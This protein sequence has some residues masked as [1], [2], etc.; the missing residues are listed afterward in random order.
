MPDDVM[1][2]DEDQDE[3]T[4]VVHDD[5]MKRLLDYQRQLRERGEAHIPAL[6]TTSLADLTTVEAQAATA[7]ATTDDVLDLTQV[8]E[9]QA[10]VEIV[11]LPEIEETKLEI[12]EEPGEDSIEEP[13]GEAETSSSTADP[14]LAARVERLESSIERIG[15]M[16][17]S[18]RSDF[19]DLTIRAD[20]RIAEIE[21]VLAEALGPR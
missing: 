21:E 3:L 19:Q 9:P 6:E 10:E 8:D 16:L 11:E 1:T 12:V 4:P 2:P 17:A 15:T 14:D 18:V 5:I 7:T 13:V 20:E